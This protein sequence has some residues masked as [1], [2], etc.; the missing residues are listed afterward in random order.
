MTPVNL[1][2]GSDTNFWPMSRTGQP[3]QFLAL[4]GSKTMLQQTVDC[5]SDLPTSEPITICNLRYQ[6]KK[7]NVNPG[8]KLSVQMHRHRAELWVIISGTARVTNGANTSL[9][10]ENQSIYM[11]VG[12]IHSL[13]NPRELPL[14][15]IEI[16]AGS[17]LGEDDIVRCE[18]IY[19]RVK[20]KSAK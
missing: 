10:I 3:K 16:Q 20:R 17:Y 7:I 12:N 2:G 5:L 9:M 4:D 8:A 11:Q 1:A 19:G 14:E 15:I 6:V 13:E 18:D